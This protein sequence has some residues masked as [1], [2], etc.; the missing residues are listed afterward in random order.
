MLRFERTSTPAHLPQIVRSPVP[1][2]TPATDTDIKSLGAKH[3]CCAVCVH[4]SCGH[5]GTLLYAWRSSAP[6][7]NVDI[8]AY[9]A[10]STTDA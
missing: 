8:K 2:E 4:C 3:P 10:L 1:L 6:G 9:T 7:L 5:P